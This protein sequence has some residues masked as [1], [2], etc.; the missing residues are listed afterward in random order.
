MSQGRD[1]TG[2]FKE[3]VTEQD[4][5][6][7]FDYEDDPVLT[8]PEVADGLRRFGKQITPEGVRNRLEEMADQGLVSR[9][10]LGARAVGWWAEVAPDLNT[11]TAE[12][13]EDRKDSDEWAEL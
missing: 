1:D 3:T 4:I 9:K 2:Q 11:E 8:A 6:K 5:L 7:V 12:T 13:V 10:K